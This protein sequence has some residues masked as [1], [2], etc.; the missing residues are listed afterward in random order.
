M[1]D[2]GACLHAS[3]YLCLHAACKRGVGDCMSE[4]LF[5][6]GE[7]RGSCGGSSMCS[8]NGSQGSCSGKRRT[9]LSSY[10]FDNSSSVCVCKGQ[11]QCVSA[12]SK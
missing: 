1:R 10:F 12:T 9:Q 8:S 6:T 3:L 5:L 11:L 7:C 4:Q 2:V